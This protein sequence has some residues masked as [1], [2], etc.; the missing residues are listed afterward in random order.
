MNIS[1]TEKLMPREEMLEVIKSKKKLTI[2][3]PSEGQRFE[4]RIAL[5]PNAVGQLVRHGHRVIIENEAGKASHFN[6]NEYSEEGGEIVYSREE[7]YK[8]DIILKVAPV[9]DKEL[10]LIRKN[11]ILISSLQVNT[12][13][14]SYFKQLMDKK[15]FGLAYELIRDETGSYPVLQAMS[16]IVG[17]AVIY[18]AAEYQSSNDFGKGNLFGGLP[19]IPPTEVV[20]IGAGTVGENAADAALSLG[21]QVKV[22]D[23]NIYKLR[24]LLKNLSSPVY[25]SIMQPKI[26]E[27]ALKTA[28]VVIGAYYFGESRNE[29]I[30]TEEMIARMKYRSLLIDVSID[31]GGCFETSSLTTHNNP[32]FKKYDIS[33]YCVPNIASK[34]ARTASYALSNFFTPLLIKIGDDGGLQ[35]LL[36]SQ[37]GLGKGVY[38]FNGILTNKQIGDLFDLP[39]KDFELLLAAL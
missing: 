21:A 20:I 37:S 8:A 30:I 7:A 10:D 18:I 22:F 39:S 16:E 13:D 34:F 38:L 36:R 33:H 19:G 4:N 11:H 26:L 32:V 12:K 3:I 35:N 6:N 23:N 17:K 31:Q 9:S 5:V 1:K 2:G 15:I 25:T 29:C 24:K 28:D 14:K 27:K